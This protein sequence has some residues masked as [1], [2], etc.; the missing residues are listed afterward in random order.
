MEDKQLRVFDTIICWPLLSIYSMIFSKVHSR[1]ILPLSSR[2]RCKLLLD[3]KISKTKATQ[4][5]EPEE[6][7]RDLSVS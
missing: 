2:T 5:I 6:N 1:S 7:A 3:I 4:G